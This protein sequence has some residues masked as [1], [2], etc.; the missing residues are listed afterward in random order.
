VPYYAS[1]FHSQWQWDS[2][3][4]SAVSQLLETVGPG[5]II[6]FKRLG[7]G[8]TKDLHA[9]LASF[10]LPLCRLARFIC[11]LRDQFP[12][13]CMLLKAVIDVFLIRNCHAATRCD[14]VPVTRGYRNTWYEVLSICHKMFSHVQHVRH[15]GQW[16]QCKLTVTVDPSFCHCRPQLC[17]VYYSST[18][19]TLAKWTAHIPLT[20]IQL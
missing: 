8:V 14:N 9:P 19:W 12:F 13:F 18:F 7:L 2:R 20:D 6:Q 10:Q 4:R 15:N 3:D 5:L 11:F 17:A 1:V 16:A